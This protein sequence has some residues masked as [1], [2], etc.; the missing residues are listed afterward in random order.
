MSDQIKEA[1]AKVKQDIDIL[2][3]EIQELK[4]LLD[5]QTN[6]QTD[7]PAHNQTE[8]TQ[9][10]TIRQINPS[11][12]D[13]PAHNPAD[14]LPFKALKSPNSSISTGNEGVPADSQQ[15][16]KQ[17]DNST[18]NKGVEFALNKKN[19]TK[20]N[21]LNKIEQLA[22]VISSLDDIKKDLRLKI[23][24]LT[25]Q[26]MAVL[27]SIYSLEEQGLIVDY[28]LLAEKLSLTES[29]IRDYIQRLIKKDIPIEKLKE[30]NKKIILSI[31]QNFKK[32]A[33]LS[34]INHLRRL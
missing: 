24:K 20:E 26:E 1:F 3:K 34:T 25:K 31:S 9:Y 21:K 15:T 16:D 29:S 2:K 17:T 14:I 4:Q 10:T 8:N 33:S 22:D 18:R 6:Q 19:N 7:N 13:I 32:I 11:E 5:R 12:T 28:S 27:T 23:K 30:N